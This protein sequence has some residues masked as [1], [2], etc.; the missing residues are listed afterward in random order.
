MTASKTDVERQHVRDPRALAFREISREPAREH[1]LLG[2]SPRAQRR[3][4]NV[5]LIRFTGHREALTVY[6]RDTSPL[7][8]TPRRFDAVVRGRNED[9]SLCDSSGSLTFR[10]REGEE[11][12]V[13]RGGY[14]GKYRRSHGTNVAKM[15][16]YV[17][18]VWLNSKRLVY[19]R[20]RPDYQW[21]V[22][23]ARSA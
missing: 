17:A 1:R 5:P 18:R 7:T 19:L 9:P 12:S 14:L 21:V 4:A 20:A 6:R 15:S 13:E 23:V 8:R 2:W 22:F 3:N 10:G 16:G 11:V